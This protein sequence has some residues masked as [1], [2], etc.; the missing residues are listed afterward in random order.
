[1]VTIDSSASR[2]ERTLGNIASP[3]RRSYASARRP[4]LL[5]MMVMFGRDVPLSLPSP[6][7]G[8]GIKNPVTGE[9]SHPKAT[10]VEHSTQG[11]I[12]RSMLP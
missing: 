4:G 3:R 11:E 5:M 12:T 2:A 8:E 1:M 9:A 6:T 7:R 10:G